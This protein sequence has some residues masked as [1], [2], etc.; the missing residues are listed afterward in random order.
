MPNGRPGDH[1]YTDIVRHDIDVHTEEVSKIVHHVAESGNDS[2]ATEASR[3]LW[4]V[5]TDNPSGEELERLTRDLY[6]LAA[7]VR[8]SANYSA[9]SPLDACLA[10]DE[11]VYA[12]P[13]RQLVRDVHQE[14]EADV[15]NDWWVH[16]ELNGIMWGFGWETDRLDEL[17]ARLQ[18]L[19]EETVRER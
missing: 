19:R 6:S 4:A 18:E 12:A 14:I 9:E 5:G 13:I 17:K 7:E 8:L 15:E 11:A 1:P 3:R 16:P 2:A 10:D